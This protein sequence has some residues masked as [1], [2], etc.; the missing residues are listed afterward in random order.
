[1]IPVLARLVTNDGWDLVDGARVGL[2]GKPA[3][4]PLVNYLANIS[5]GLAASVM[6]LKWLPDL[7]SGNASLP[8]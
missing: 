1:M 2:T 5:F 6:F 3:A 8:E 4:M 7:H